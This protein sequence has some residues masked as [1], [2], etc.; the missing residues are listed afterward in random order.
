MGPGTELIM[1]TDR[2]YCEELFV[3]CSFEYGGGNYLL[4]IDE[5]DKH[6]CK[7][8]K[9]G[10]WK[11][12][13]TDSSPVGAEVRKICKTLLKRSV[14]DEAFFSLNGE[15]YKIFIEG[16]NMRIGKRR[17]SAVPGR[18]GRRVSRLFRLFVAVLLALAAGFIFL[19]TPESRIASSV[20]GKSDVTSLA[21]M[22][23]I[24]QSYGAFLLFELRSFHR[25]LPDLA[26]NAV[27]PYY[28]IA[29]VGAFRANGRVRFTVITIAAVFLLICIYRSVTAKSR[30]QLASRLSA[31]VRSCFTPFVL[32]LCAAFIAIHF[33]G[34]P[35]RVYT[36]ELAAK[37]GVLTEESFDEARESLRSDVWSASD[38]QQKLDILQTIC[39]YECLNVLG[40][41]PPR[42]YAGDT[43]SESI[44]G[45]F[46]PD[47]YKITISARILETE[48]AETVLI[49]LLHEVRHAY[50]H[51]VAEVFD[52]IEDRLNDDAKA[53]EVIRTMESYRYEFNNYVYGLE[54]FNA[55]HAQTIEADS[56]S[57]SEQK[58]KTEYYSYLYPDS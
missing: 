26:F 28:T 8:I 32:C 29:L 56:R 34:I 12:V 45:S 31:S 40:I 16:R 47:P 1:N 36:S 24:I 44:F 21:I 52:T 25:E 11:G 58:A 27:V 6:V 37:N 55:Y 54:D 53:L 35:L 41:D 39:D 49:T 5:N 14:T 48:L 3:L 43:G 10:I 13:Y 57:W 2:G 19:H 22:V 50:Q 7:R 38:D 30:S 15:H 51:A 4:A 42:V 9:F 23:Y 33:F 20:L 18:T 46:S 17:K